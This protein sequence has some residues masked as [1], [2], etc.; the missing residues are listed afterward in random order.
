MT[1]A[2]IYPAQA[3]DRNDLH[4]LEIKCYDYP[5][6]KDDWA[7]ILKIGEGAFDSFR[8]E[9][10]KRNG[11]ILGYFVY[12]EPSLPMDD[13]QLDDLLLFRVGVQPSL[14]KQGI[15]SMLLDRVRD[16]CQQRELGEF[17]I[18]VPEYFLDKEENRGLSDFYRTNGLEYYSTEKDSYYH[19]GRYFDGITYRSGGKRE[20]LPCGS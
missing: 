13:G 1:I 6:N 2:N 11:M 18:R 16:L 8:A 15:G 4:Q 12:M 5:L 14:R 7:S 3:I 19:Y 20:P 10:F 9:V 17:Q